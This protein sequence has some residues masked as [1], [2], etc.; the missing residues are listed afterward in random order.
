MVRDAGHEIGLHGYSHE[1]PIDM[2]L[3]QQRDVLDYSYKM[4]TKFCGKPPRGIV[5]PW[6]EV[7]KEGANLLLEYGIEYDH[8]MNHEDHTPYYLR[9]G[10]EWTKIDYSKKASD[11]MVRM[12]PSPQQ[13]RGSRSIASPKAGTS[14]WLGR[15]KDDYLTP[16]GA[17]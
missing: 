2:S 6:W 15:G 10:D 13:S 11:W 5:A 12:S 3:E 7:S 17:D 1:N 4:L 14:H 9:T 16:E 8:S